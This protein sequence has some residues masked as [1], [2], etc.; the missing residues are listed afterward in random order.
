MDEKNTLYIL[1][2]NADIHTSQFMVFMYAKNS[3]LRNWWEN[4]TVIIWGATAKLAAENTVIREE[5]KT[6][7][8]AGVRFSACIACAER[9][10]VV[11]ELEAQGIEVKPWGLPLTELL[12]TNEKLITI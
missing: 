9:L 1:W 4:V 2:T 10:G 5:I 7:Q 8:L 11:G 6:A 3:M 12:K